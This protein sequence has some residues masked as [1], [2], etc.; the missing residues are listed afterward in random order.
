MYLR[1][2]LT[3]KQILPRIPYGLTRL[4]LLCSGGKSLHQNPCCYC[5]FRRFLALSLF[6]FSP[7]LHTLSFF[8]FYRSDLQY[9]SSLREAKQSNKS[10]GEGILGIHFIQ[11]DTPRL[12]SAGVTVFN[13]VHGRANSVSPQY[14]L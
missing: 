1:Y 10:I 2:S 7:S 11:I 12:T 4:S 14:I 3:S 5:H 6:S 9:V 8:I 13:S